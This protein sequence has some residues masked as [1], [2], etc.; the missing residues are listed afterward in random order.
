MEQRV[1]ITR[2]ESD[3]IYN[4]YSTHIAYMNILQYLMSTG[5]IKDVAF[6]DKKW[7][8]AIAINI[9][10]DA[11]KRKIERK[12]KPAGRWDRF[13]FDFENQTV[14]FVNNVS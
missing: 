14:V 2:E 3:K 12:Y 13:E 8:E 6:Y 11:E 5:T 9:E 7:N 1:K 4:L 10:L